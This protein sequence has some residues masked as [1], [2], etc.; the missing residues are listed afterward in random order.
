MPKNKTKTNTRLQPCLENFPP[1]LRLHS[2]CTSTESRYKKFAFVRMKAGVDRLGVGLQCNRVLLACPRNWV[3]RTPTAHYHAAAWTFLLCH[4]RVEKLRNK[5]FTLV[6]GLGFFFFLLPQ[7]GHLKLM[8]WKGEIRENSPFMPGL[9][10][11][12]PKSSSRHLEEGRRPST[13]LWMQI[14]P[15]QGRKSGNHF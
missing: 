8:F 14:K 10:V 11:G 5:L 3:N 15:L 12:R 4:F 7:T 13:D 6:S 2:V 9:T 1:F